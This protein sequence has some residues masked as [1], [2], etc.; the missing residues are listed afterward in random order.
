[1]TLRWSIYS[2]KDAQDSIF[3]VNRILISSSSLIDMKR[4]VLLSAVLLGAVSASQAGVH[5]N[6]GLPLPPLPLPGI[7]I[8]RPAPVV[9]APPVCAAPAPVYEA[10]SVVIQPP[11]FYLGIGPRYYD[12]GCAPRY[13][14]RDYYPRYHRGYDRGYG[15][16]GGHGYSPYRGSPDR[17]YRCRQLFKILPFLPRPNRKVR[18]FSFFCHR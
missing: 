1:M 7:I 4:I 16:Y 18:P 14:S 8:G 9:V 3:V 5:L 2:K 11:S 17:H 6:I 13:Y 12:R 10:P 15:Y